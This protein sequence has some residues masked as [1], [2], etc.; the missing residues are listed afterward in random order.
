MVFP[1]FS[2]AARR[3]RRMVARWALW[4]GPHVDRLVIRMFT[5]VSTGGSELAGST[6]WPEMVPAR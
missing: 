3:P 2:A 1:Q 5:A 6:F 4:S